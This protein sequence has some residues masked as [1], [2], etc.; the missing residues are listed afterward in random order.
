MPSIGGKILKITVAE[1]AGF[2]FGVNRAIQMILE[3]L[4]AGKKSVHV[5][6]YYS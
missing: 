1:T 6:P 3:L 2:C 5:R 4:D